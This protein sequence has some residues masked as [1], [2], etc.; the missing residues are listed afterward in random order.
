M[1]RAVVWVAFGGLAASVLYIL[2]T[3]RQG[4]SGIVSRVHAD[5]NDKEGQKTC[6]NASLKSAYAFQRMGHTPHGELTAI[7]IVTFDGNG[8]NTARQTIRRN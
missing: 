8:S 6:S 3:L 1:R 5:D 2:P 7:G 4:G